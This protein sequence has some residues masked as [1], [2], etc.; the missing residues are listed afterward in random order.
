LLLFGAII[1]MRSLSEEKKL[2]TWELLL[3]SPVR[4]AEVVMGKFFAAV[5][6][7]AIMLVLTMYYPL[8]F[9]VFK[10]TS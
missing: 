1:T 9:A 5:G 8:L 4:D 7:M 6:I 2:G 3:T 10:S